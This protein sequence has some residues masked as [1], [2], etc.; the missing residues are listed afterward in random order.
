VEKKEKYQNLLII[1]QLAKTDFKLRYND[2]VL[3]YFW[4]LLKPLS[5]FIILNFVFSHIFGVTD[6]LYSLK[7]LTSLMIWNFFAEGTLTGLCSI[8]AKAG[9]LT[10]IY[11]PKWTM[12]IA[13]IS[14]ILITYLINIIVIALFFI[15]YRYTPDFR[16]II[17]FFIYSFYTYILI[18]SISFITSPFYVKFK[19]LRQIWEVIITAGFYASPIIYP[20]TAIPEVFHWILH[21]NPMTFIIQY[22]QATLFDPAFE[23]RLIPNIIYL[24]FLTTLFGFSILIFKKN[25]K[26]LVEKM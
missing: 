5:I 25:S 18:L 17:S 10:K 8:Q 3:G 19:D 21:L 9:I 26:K 23:F 4:S 2:S 14:H 12:I 24:L 15:F 16:G 11:L 22:T 6:N 7:L 1:K 13:A 20:M